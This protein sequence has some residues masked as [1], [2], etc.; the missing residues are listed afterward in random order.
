L[1]EA[2]TLRDEFRQAYRKEP[3]LFRAPG[4]VNLIGEHTD[5]ND[6]FVMPVAIDFYTWAAIAPRGDS[7]LNVQSTTLHD[8]F[9]IVLNEALQPRHRWSDYVVGVVDQLQRRGTTLKGA[10]LLIHGEVPVGAGL[11]SSAAIEV[12]TGLALSSVSGED[13]DRK[14]LALLCQRAE[15]EFVGMRC[16]IMDQFISA[17]GRRGHA[18]LLDC[19]SLDFKLLPLANNAKIVICNTMVK[20]EL[21]SGEYN[22]RRADCEEGVRIL[23]QF[24]PG[25]RALRDVSLADLERFK[26][27]LPDPINR[28]CRHVVTENARVLKAAE[29]LERNDLAAFG[30]LMYQSHTSLRDDYE[31]SCRELDTMVD[32]AS[33]LAGVYGARMTGGGFG[34]C[35]VAL[36][37]S[38]QANRFQDQI[39]AGYQEATG[40][41]PE[42]YISNAA[43]GA[44]RI[45]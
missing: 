9:S 16:G 42:I 17:N 11:S 29:M 41:R 21:A 6:G 19:R 35:A 4:R 25:I 39:A 34:G 30:E 5:Y 33:K 28:R 7:A 20:H 14:S 22:R 24:L 31:V 43:D 44:S 2:Q 10:D 13:L 40:I 18:L 37:E 15:N 36:V 27:K 1:I 38:E 45:A 32:L 8:S 3:Q 26:D 12:S 23:S